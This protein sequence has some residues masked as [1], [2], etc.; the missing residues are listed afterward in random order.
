MTASQHDAY[1]MEYDAQVRAYDCYLADA[2]FGMCFEYIHPGERLLDAG[3]GSGLSGILFAK[4]GLSVYGMDFSPAMLE[5]CHAK[6]FA[7]E[8]KEHD[9]LLTPW[10]YPSDAFDHIVSCGVFHFLPDLET[11]FGEVQRVIRP[12][13]IFAFTT[14]APPAAAGNHPKYSYEKIDDMD[15]FSH[16]PAYLD[17]LMHH[18]Q[19]KRLK[20][21]KCTVGQDAHIWV[22]TEIPT[23][24]P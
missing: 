20:L 8:L 19:F 2:L 15:I 4:A 18:Y 17:D 13:G 21:L 11:V 22:S 5:L 14:K 9:I 16:Y 1:A 3:I 7:A 24:L 12:G 23:S 6:G 10:P